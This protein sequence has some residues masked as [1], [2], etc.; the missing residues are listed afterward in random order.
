MRLGIE[1]SAAGGGER[2]EL[3]RIV[4]GQDENALGYSLVSGAPAVVSVTAIGRGLWAAE[5]HVQRDSWG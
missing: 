3:N 5:G 1:D 4:G 2:K